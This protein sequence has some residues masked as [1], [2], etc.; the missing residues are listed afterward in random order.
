MTVMFNAHRTAEQLL[1]FP[2]I[3]R[4]SLNTRMLVK[5]GLKVVNGRG[6]L[7]NISIQTAGPNGRQQYIPKRQFMLHQALA[8]FIVTA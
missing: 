3:E 8:A 4:N 2:A 6:F 7:L 1:R 5:K